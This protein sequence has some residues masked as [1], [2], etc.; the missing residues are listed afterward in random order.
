LEKLAQSSDTLALQSLI[1]S[2]LNDENPGVRLKAIRSLHNFAL[3]PQ[4]KMAYMKA[5]MTDVNPA[6]RIEAVSGLRKMILDE[7]VQEVMLIA[8]RK[9][10]NDYVRLLGREALETLK[11][12]SLPENLRENDF[13][14]EDLR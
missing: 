8:S 14:I 4:T 2:L 13:Q 10:S 9:D 7:Q 1:Y 3:N 11:N 5:L 12:K 6:V